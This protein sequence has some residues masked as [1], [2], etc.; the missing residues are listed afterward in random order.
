MDTLKQLAEEG[1]KLHYEGIQVSNFRLHCKPCR[2]EQEWYKVFDHMATTNHKKALPYAKE[3]PRL[4]AS[5]IPPSEQQAWA[6]LLRSGTGRPAGLAPAINS[7][8][9]AASSSSAAAQHAAKRAG[10]TAQQHVAKRAC[11]DSETSVVGPSSTSATD[12][13]PI[14]IPR[15]CEHEPAPAANV[16]NELVQ[17]A[18]KKWY[19]KLQEPLCWGLDGRKNGFWIFCADDR[20][21]P[22]CNGCGKFVGW[23]YLNYNINKPEVDPDGSCPH[24][25]AANKAALLAELQN[26]CQ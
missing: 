21:R 10:S 12:A 11:I 19:P 16:L 8:S 6:E 25:T 22:G 4:P 15:G 20:Q 2:R 13:T 3:L 14:V 24:Y 17:K 18:E 5:G 1:G 23:A 26:R 7:S 9:A